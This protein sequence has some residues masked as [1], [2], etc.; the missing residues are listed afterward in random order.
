MTNQDAESR[1]SDMADAVIATILRLLKGAADSASP[2]KLMRDEV[3]FNLSAGI[4]EGM[5]MPSANKLLEDSSGNVIQQIVRNFQQGNGAQTVTSHV[6]RQPEQNMMSMQGVTREYH[7][8]MN[9]T[10]EMAR[11]VDYNFQL[12]ETLYG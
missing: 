8:H 6:L 5:I 4:A 12:M 7:M 11:R 10:P 2:S 9:I 3:G 1:F